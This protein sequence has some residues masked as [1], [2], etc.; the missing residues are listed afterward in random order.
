MGLAVLY[1]RHR[2]PVRARWRWQ[3]LRLRLEGTPYGNGMLVVGT[4]CADVLV[5]EK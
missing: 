1:R 5:A 4:K 2:S 3:L